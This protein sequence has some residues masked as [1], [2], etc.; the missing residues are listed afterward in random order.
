MSTTDIKRTLR[1]RYGKAALRVATGTKS[2]GCLARA[3]L[4][5]EVLAREVG[6]RV[7]GAFIRARKPAPTT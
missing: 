7:T 2:G 5:T 3:G 1:H 6:G 4:D